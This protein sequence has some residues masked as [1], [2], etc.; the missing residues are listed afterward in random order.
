VRLS[1][2][3]RLLKFT[4]LFVIAMA[5]LLAIVGAGYERIASARDRRWYPPPGKLVDIGGR[6]LHIH[7]TGQGL[8]RR[9]RKRS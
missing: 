4:L 3:W 5:A 6:R 7:C 1:N 8:D 9:N 2:D